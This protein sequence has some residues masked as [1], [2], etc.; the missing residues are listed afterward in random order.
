VGVEQ[1]PKDN[2]LAALRERIDFQ[3][4]LTELEAKSKQ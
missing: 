1:L 4:R 2:H 3:K